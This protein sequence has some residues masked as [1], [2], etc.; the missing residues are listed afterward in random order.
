M[1]MPAVAD[2]GVQA[3]YGSM[4]A[5]ASQLSVSADGLAQVVGETL[6]SCGNATLDAALGDFAGQFKGAVANLSSGTSTEGTV[7]NAVVANFHQ[8]DGS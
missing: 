7:V 1:T 4:V 2:G 6:A 8:A 3:T 5:L